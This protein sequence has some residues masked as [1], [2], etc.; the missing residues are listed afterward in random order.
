MI[1]YIALLP[2]HAFSDFDESELHARADF[3]KPD[4]SPV[5]LLVISPNVVIHKRNSVAIVAS[6]RR[7]RR[8]RRLVAIVITIYMPLTTVLDR[9]AQILGHVKH[10]SS[11]AT[12][13]MSP[14]LGL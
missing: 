10:P 6:S 4:C 14:Q 3:V 8:G 11:L 7:S 13:E 5:A 9:L 2:R 1:K 12:S